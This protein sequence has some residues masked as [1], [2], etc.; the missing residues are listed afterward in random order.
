MSDNS[1]TV[2]EILKKAFNR[3]VGGGTAGA[4]AM[5]LNVF[6]LMWIRT[7]M[8]YQYKHGVSFSEALDALNKEGGISRFYQ[9]LTAALIQAPLSR[10]GDTA[11]NTGGLQL[12]NDLESTKN[13]P[14]I[15]KTFFASCGASVWRIFLSPVDAVKTNMQVNGN[16]DELK[17]KINKEGILSVYDGSLLAAGSTLVGHFPWFI[18]FNQLDAS[19]PK[20]KSALGKLIRSACIG[21]LCS[22]VSD[23][24]SNFLKV[25]KTRVQ[26]GDTSYSEVIQEMYA[27]DGVFMLFRGLKTKLLSNV[28]SSIMFSVMWKYFEAKLNQ[29]D[30]ET[31]YTPV[32]T[33]EPKDSKGSV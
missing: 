3:A 29:P 12:L 20:A 33:E 28:L 13:L 16:L 11:A 32:A 31:A 24:C 26:T 5:V 23:T 18:T 22:L 9:G 19:V 30:G 2:D 8:N 6:T 25:L 4:M 27:T 1:L 21:F 14:L 15:L 10:F 17:R 7:T